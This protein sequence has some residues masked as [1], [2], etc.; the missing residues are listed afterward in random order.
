MLTYIEAKELNVVSALSLSTLVLNNSR[1]CHEN[2]WLPNF[3][4][5]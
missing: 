3:S 5:F 4:H 1:D 2:L